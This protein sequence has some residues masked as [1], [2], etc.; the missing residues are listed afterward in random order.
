MVLS[1]NTLMMNVVD[2]S[3]S[4]QMKQ[5]V[6]YWV[7]EM[8]KG[9]IDVRSQL[10]QELHSSDVY[11]DLSGC[12]VLHIKYIQLYTATLSVSVNR[13][14]EQTEIWITD[15]AVRV[16]LFTAQVLYWAS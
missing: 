11:V 1:V 15:S 14:T 3:D 9:R 8:M 2:C 7:N 5:V 12:R 10:W 6:K 13:T 4:W 16:Q